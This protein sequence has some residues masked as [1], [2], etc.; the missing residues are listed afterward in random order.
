MAFCHEHDAIQVLHHLNNLRL[1]AAQ[2]ILDEAMSFEF[3]T[4]N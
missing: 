2:Y 4:A 1:S 3:Q